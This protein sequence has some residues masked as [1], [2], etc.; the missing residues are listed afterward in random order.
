MELVAGRDQEIKYF[1]WG[2]SERF[3]R[4][5]IL[6]ASLREGVQGILSRY[7][8]LEE[9]LG[10]VEL[11]LEVGVDAF[12]IGFPIAN[13]E[14]K[15]HTLQVARFLAGR[16][17][18]LRLVCL[19]RTRTEDVMAVVEVSQA[20]GVKL[21]VLI[22]IGTSSTRLLV[23]QASIHDLVDATTLAVD[24]AVRHGLTVNFACQ[25]ATRSEPGLLRL[26]YTA[27]LDSGASRLTIPD[28]VGAGNALATGRIVKYV[29]DYVIRNRGVGLD[30][31]GH[32]D[33]GLA[34]SNALAA[35]AAGAGCLHATVLGIGERCGSVALEPL[36]VNL[37]QLGGAHYNLTVLPRLAEYAAAIFGEPLPPRQRS[38]YQGY[39]QANHYRRNSEPANLAS[40][41]VGAP[42]SGFDHLCRGG[43]TPGK[44]YP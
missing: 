27:A 6:D 29:R 19:A 38:P 18:E 36:L 3:P 25:D 40:R 43:S 7:P 17:P 28:T 31:Q 24:L 21:E 41:R 15:L 30:W 10:L 11:L 23:E 5:T 22:Y 44:P 1:D 9:K 4:P 2:S 34:V 8:T 35:A 33:R 14:Q 32:N 16:Q 42:G 20:A 39:H 26:L 13:P 12:D 37:S